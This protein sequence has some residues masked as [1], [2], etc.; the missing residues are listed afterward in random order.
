MG[1]HTVSFPKPPTGLEFGRRDSIA[2]I[3]DHAAPT[4]E[5]D[6]DKDTLGIRIQRILGQLDDDSAQAG[7]GG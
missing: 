7:D 5:V 2:V 3:L 6:R 1:P 4:L